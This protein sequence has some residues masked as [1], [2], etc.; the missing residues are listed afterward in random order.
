MYTETSS[1]RKQ[2]DKARLA[3]K[4][5]P[6]TNNMCLTFWYHMYGSN[7]GTLNVYTSSF[8]HLGSTVWS[9]YGN[10]GNQWRKAQKT[11]QTATQYQV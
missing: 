1:P 8:G 4:T 6:A 11:L 7:I 2:G 3:S 5:Y 10:Q 9:Q